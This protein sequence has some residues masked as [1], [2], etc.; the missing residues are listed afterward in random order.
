MRWS[1]RLMSPLV[2]KSCWVKK[3]GAVGVSAPTSMGTE[4]PVALLVTVTPWLESA[5]GRWQHIRQRVDSD[6]AYAGPWSSRQGI[7]GSKA[8]CSGHEAHVAWRRGLP[9]GRILVGPEEEELVPDRRATY[10]SPST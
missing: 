8:V 7:Q 5:R 2:W 6:L 4:A 10:C 3:F 9:Q 1:P